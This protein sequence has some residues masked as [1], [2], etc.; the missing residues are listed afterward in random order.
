M[1]KLIR[2]GM[3]ELASQQEKL[4]EPV[5]SVSNTKIHNL[6]TSDEIPIRIYRPA[7]KKI[8]EKQLPYPLIV[9]FHGGGWV[10]GDLDIY[11]DLCRSLSFRCKSIVISVDY[12]LA[13]EHKFPAGLEDCYSAV[14]WAATHASELNADASK[15]IVAG[16][17]AGGNLASATALRASQ[18]DGPHI[19]LQILIYPATHCYFD[20]PSYHQNTKGYAVTQAAIKYCWNTYLFG[21]AT[22]SELNTSPLVSDPYVSPLRA[23]NFQQFPRTLIITAKYDVLLDEGESYA[24]KLQKNGISVTL[25]RYPQQHGFMEQSKNK[26]REKAIAL[27]AREVKANPISSLISIPHQLVL[28]RILYS[29]NT[30]WKMHKLLKKNGFFGSPVDKN[31]KKESFRHTREDP[32]R[33]DYINFVQLR[34]LRRS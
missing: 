23:K 4:A 1:Y 6:T 25:A 31:L 19:A 8:D 28:S 27:I 21:E 15:L 11:D 12:R 30:K 14:K 22:S 17:S 16:D 5:E 3:S 33:E 13:P 32:T 10:A 29:N 24:E 7:Q 9:Y 26:Y 2:Q 34:V 18:S 20:T